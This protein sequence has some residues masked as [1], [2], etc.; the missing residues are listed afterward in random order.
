MAAVT[1]VGSAALAPSAQA[2]TS[3]A[4]AA[5]VAAEDARIAA[6]VKAGDPSIVPLAKKRG[7]KYKTYQATA[8]YGY[9][10]PFWGK[11]RNTAGCTVAYFTLSG[12]VAYN[13]KQAWGQWISYGSGHAYG[14]S[15]KKT[16]LGYWN[17]GAK[18]RPYYMDLGANGHVSVKFFEAHDFYLRIDV[19]R[20]GTAGLRGGAA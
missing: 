20:N 14:V 15:V 17:N 6:Q 4:A 13:G 7:W 10:H 12:E 1:A 19:H 9:K 5:R 3:T 8:C 18:K 11:K 2:A 16:W